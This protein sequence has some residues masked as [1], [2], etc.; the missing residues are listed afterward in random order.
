MSV[1]VFT[2]FVSVALAAYFGLS[3]LYYHDYAS[4]DE[5]R[6]SLLP[7][8]REEVKSRGDG[9]GNKSDGSEREEV[10]R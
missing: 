5:M 8:G 9:K 4:G 6:D 7:F 1:L 10:A 2:I 3:Y